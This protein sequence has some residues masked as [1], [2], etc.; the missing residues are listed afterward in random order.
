MPTTGTTTTAGTPEPATLAVA[1][2][3]REL[4]CSTKTVRRRVQD[5]VIQAIRLGR[6]IRI[7][8]SELERIKQ[9]KAPRPTAPTNDNLGGSS[10]RDPP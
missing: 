2:F 7:P 5:G 10:R 3:A 1:Q 8:R 9:L 4:Q 6:L